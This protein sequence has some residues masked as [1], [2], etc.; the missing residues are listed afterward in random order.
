MTVKEGLKADLKS[1][2]FSIY[3]QWWGIFMVVLSLALGIANL[4]REKKLI[5]FGV[6]AIVQGIILAFVEIPFLHNLLPVN[7]IALVDSN[8]KRTALYVVFAIIQFLSLIVSKNSSLIALAVCYL[9]GAFL[10]GLA[11]GLNQ[12]FHDSNV[13]Y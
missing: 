4:F 2:N 8:W 10:Y 13:V 9:V 12:E 7:L 11:A 3:G 1:K 6:L 5:V